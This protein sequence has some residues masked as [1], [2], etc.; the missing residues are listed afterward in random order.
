MR[1]TILIINL[2]AAVALQVLAGFAT[3]AHRTHAYS[4]YRELVENRA[5]VERPTKTNGDPFD[6]EA[7]LRTI[8]SG[9][10][11]SLL[12]HIGSAACVITGLVFFVTCGPSRRN[13]LVSADA[14]NIHRTA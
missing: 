6:V 4:V 11:Y 3:A 14:K 8:G 12:A 2:I 5:L 13:E 1:W 10:Y 7:R 9:G